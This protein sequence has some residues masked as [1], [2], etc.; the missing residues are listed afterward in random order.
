MILK[1]R[2]LANSGMT[3]DLTS[4]YFSAFCMGSASRHDVQRLNEWDRIGLRNTHA[5][6]PWLTPFL[7]PAPP[8]RSQGDEDDESSSSALAVGISLGLLCAALAVALGTVSYKLHRARGGRDLFA[9]FGFVH[10]GSRMWGGGYF[11]HA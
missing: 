8:A 5:I 11:Y 2:P 1:V 3:R 9:N 4:A 7:L 10:P 6:I